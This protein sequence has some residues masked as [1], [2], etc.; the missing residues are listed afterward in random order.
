LYS[1]GNEA[2]I[3]YHKWCGLSIL[4]AAAGRKFKVNFGNIII[5]PNLYVFLVGAPASGKS[6]AMSIAR[7]LLATSPNQFIAPSS[8]TTE[9][10]TQLMGKADGTS[11]KQTFI[12]EGGTTH[13]FLQV[14][15]FSNEIVTLLGANPQGMMD[16]LTD[17][18]E[19]EP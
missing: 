1:S 9:A 10:L 18:Y 6:T 3:D 7:R 14:N 4:S 15:I 8:M 12:D 19:C 5:Y 2:S 13:D 11:I 16:M 17:I